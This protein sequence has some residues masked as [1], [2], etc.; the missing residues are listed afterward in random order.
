MSHPTVLGMPASD[1]GYV[2]LERLGE[3]GWTVTVEPHE[4]GIVVRAINGHY[5]VELAG[6]S[7][8]DLGLRV[9]EAATHP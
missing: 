9:Y 3:Q 8:A 5:D 1:A 7:V 6:A 2:W 4:Q